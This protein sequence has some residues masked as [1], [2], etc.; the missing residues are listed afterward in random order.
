MAWEMLRREGMDDFDKKI[1]VFNKGLV[2]RFNATPFLMTR[3]NG[4]DFRIISEVFYRNG[5]Y[6]EYP[7]HKHLTNKEYE[8]RNNL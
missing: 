2:D 6:L 4:K 8:Q 5:R 7:F 3:G 1:E